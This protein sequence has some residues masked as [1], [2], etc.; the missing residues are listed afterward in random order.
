MMIAKKPLQNLKRQK[1]FTLKSL[2]NNQTQLS[3]QSAGTKWGN[4]IRNYVGRPM[5]D[6]YMLK[7]I[8]TVNT[9][10]DVAKYAKYGTQTI[11]DF[12]Y[13]DTNNDGV[14]TTSDY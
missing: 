9:A 2:A 12:R 7:V 3:N 5:G 8:G 13:E 6:M 11:G 10:E 4:V 14:I 1:S